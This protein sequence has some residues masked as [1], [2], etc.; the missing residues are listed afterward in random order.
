MMYGFMDGGF[1]GM[2]YGMLLLIAIIF[3][4]GLAVGYMFGRSR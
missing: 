3:A 2:G 1:F 4:A